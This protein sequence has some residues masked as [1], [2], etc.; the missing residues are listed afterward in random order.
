MINEILAKC[1][2]HP[3]IGMGATILSYSDRN[4]ATVIG[5]D[6]V[7][8]I[9]TVRLDDYKRIDNNDCSESQEYEYYQNDKNPTYSFRWSDKGWTEVVFNYNTNRWNKVKYYRCL[10]TGIRRRYTGQ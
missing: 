5:Y 10:C 1:S 3:Q 4:P 7:K 6:M 8:N 2:K 9:V